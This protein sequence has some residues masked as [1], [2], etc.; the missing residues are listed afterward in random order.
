MR[1][2]ILYCPRARNRCLLAYLN[3]VVEAKMFEGVF[4]GVEKCAKLK[5]QLLKN[6]L[7]HKSVCATDYPVEGNISK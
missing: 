2:F 7:V 6:R 1:N 4:Y 5:N 3:Q